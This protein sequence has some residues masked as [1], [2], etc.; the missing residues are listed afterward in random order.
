MEFHQ[1]WLEAENRNEWNSSKVF[2]RIV[3][4]SQ[5]RPRT[6]KAKFW[7][8]PEV[9]LIRWSRETTINSSNNFTYLNFLPRAKRYLWVWGWVGTEYLY[10]AGECLKFS[11]SLQGFRVSP[12]AT[13]RP[14]L[15]SL[16]PLPKQEGIRL[17]LLLPGGVIKRV[18]S[19]ACRETAPGASESQSRVL[20]ITS[21]SPLWCVLGVAGGGYSL[22]IVGFPRLELVAVFGAQTTW[23]R[24]SAWAG[25]QDQ[26]TVQSAFFDPLKWMWSVLPMKA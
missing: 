7:R 25:S 16:S 5:P 22:G 20:Q 10:I 19:L 12:R 4:F 8:S 13:A 11:L 1:L 17:M 18:W 23:S 15:R 9:Q 2:W 21:K 3:D 14:W 24:A 6:W 26:N